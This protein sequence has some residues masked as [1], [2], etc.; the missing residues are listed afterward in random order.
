MTDVIWKARSPLRMDFVGMTDQHH[1]SRRSG[2]SVVN[3]AIGPYLEATLVPRSDGRVTITAH[4]L[5]RSL[6]AKTANSLSARGPLA[7][8]GSVVRQFADDLRDGV[9][10]ATYCPLPGGS[11]LGSS[12]AVSACLIALLAAY[13]GH[14]LGPTQTAER[15]IAAERDANRSWYGW[16]DQYGPVTGGGI[17]FLH[18]PRGGKQ[19]P[20]VE[21]ISLSQAAAADLESNLLLCDTGVRRQARSILDKV[22]AAIAAGDDGVISALR[23]MNGLAV[24]LRD[25][26][27]AERM[28]ALPALLDAVWSAHCRLHPSVTSHRIERLISRA[29]EHG[30]LGA[31]VCGAGGGGALMLYCDH[32]AAG[33]VREA[34]ASLGAGAIDYRIVP[35]GLQIWRAAPRPGDW[36]EICTRGPRGRRSGPARRRR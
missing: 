27:R 26:L 29:R 13:C 32:G 8:L 6:A 35:C 15:A 5:G 24:R 7:L 33:R 9:D 4:D 12:S 28:H 34:L 1:F 17:K 21:S 22:S 18:W 11:G 3:A 2:G 25:A 10:I 20:A 23:E 36:R 16:Q 14:R 31:R 19:G 30:A